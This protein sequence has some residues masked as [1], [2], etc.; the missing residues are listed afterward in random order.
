MHVPETHGF[1]VQVAATG[2][3]QLAPLHCGGHV[4]WYDDP[5]AVQRPSFRHGL[6]EQGPTA[7]GVAPCW[8]AGLQSPA[9]YW[10]ARTSQA[11]SQRAFP[12]QYHGHPGAQKIALLLGLTS[13]LPL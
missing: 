2:W 13:V 11:D 7:A 12:T 4:H 3:L 9:S 1:G 8:L 6:G 10:Q 5:T